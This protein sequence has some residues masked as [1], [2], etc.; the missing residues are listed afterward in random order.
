MKVKRLIF[1]LLGLYLTFFT[2]TMVCLAQFETIKRAPWQHDAQYLD[3]ENETES[4]TIDISDEQQPVKKQNCNV[5]PTDTTFNSMEKR[6][7]LLKKRTS[8]SLPLSFIHITSGYGYRKDPVNK[9]RAFHDGIDLRCR[10]Q[11]V[12]AMMRGV[13]EEVGRGDTGYGNY[14][15]VRHGDL[16]CLYGHL[17]TITVVKG[18]MV[19]AGEQIAIS[20]NTGKSTGPHLHIRITDGVSSLNPLPLLAYIDGGIEHLDKMLTDV[21]EEDGSLTYRNLWRTMRRYGIHHKEVVMA[22]ALVETGFFSSRVCLEYN[23]LFGLRR[24]S[25]GRYYIFDDWRESVKAYRDY[26]QYKYKGGDYLQFLKKI[27]YAEDPKYITKV[28]SM[29]SRMAAN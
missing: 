28:R 8:L 11:P 3:K 7:M 20:G 19:K 10:Y 14:V 18:Q 26:V 22:Q 2:Q 25:D 15:V 13:V 16:R 21:D 9:G 27:G 29:I 1:S 4:Q 23:N 5:L 12:Y 24:P 6:L 17:S